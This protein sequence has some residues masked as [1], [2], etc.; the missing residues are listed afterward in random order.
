M[1]IQ[2]IQEA[3]KEKSNNE[4]EIECIYSDDSAQDV[5]MKLEL[6]KKVQIIS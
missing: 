4:N 6:N 3:I 1:S 2:E 5:I